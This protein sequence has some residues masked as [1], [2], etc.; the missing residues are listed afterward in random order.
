MA[1]IKGVITGVGRKKLCEAH[2]GTSTLAPITQMAFGDGGVNE[3]GVPK[4]TTGDETGLYNELMRKNVETPVYVN[5]GH[6]TC[7]YS[8]T[9]EDN[10]L[11][12]KEISEVALYDSDGDMVMIQ[13]FT[14]K[15]KDEG[16]PHKYE[17]DEIF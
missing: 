17:V 11:V 15:G 5:D 2:A 1:A 6:T 9:L 3:N 4:T 14:R 12:G 13:T 10:E 8:A 7:R 16:M